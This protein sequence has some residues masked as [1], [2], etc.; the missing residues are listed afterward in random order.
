MEL[1]RGQSVKNRF[2]PRDAFRMSAAGVVVKASWMGDQQ[3]RH[4]D[5]FFYAVATATANL[6]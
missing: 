5:I 1:W 2:Q 6:G 3:R 4:G